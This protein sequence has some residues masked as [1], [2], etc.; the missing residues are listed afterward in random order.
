[1]LIKSFKRKRKRCPCYVFAS[2]ASPPTSPPPDPAPLPCSL[3]FSWAS[4]R[5]HS[6]LFRSFLAA[7]D[8]GA[9]L[10][11]LKLSCSPA[12][13]APH[14]SF[15]PNPLLSFL[16]P[17][18]S[19][20]TMVFLWVLS[21]CLVCLIDILPVADVILRPITQGQTP[22]LS[23]RPSHPDSCY[24]VALE[25]SRAPQSPHD[26]NSTHLPSPVPHHTWPSN[27]YPLL[28]E[29]PFW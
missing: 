29:L 22:L 27:L 26:S 7:L 9:H 6:T 11:L 13:T 25:V 12:F 17:L 14:P 20:Y 4:S 3:L 18:L 21:Y 24:S 28:L 5:V 1:M 19:S 23:F 2:H 8:P 16:C 10:F 15:P